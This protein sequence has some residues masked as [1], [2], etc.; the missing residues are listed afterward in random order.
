VSTRARTLA[1]AGLVVTGAFFVSR[2][3]GWL[4]TV[5]TAYLFGASPDLDAY[6]AAFRI[7]DAI[8]QL[9]AAG[10]LSS[11]LIPVLSGLIANGEDSR[12]WRVVS[13]VVNL[14]LLALAAL[15]VVLAIAAP[16]IVPAITPGFDPAQTEL[17]VRL[18]RIML[19]SPTLLA[20]GAVATSVLNTMGRFSAS[21]LAPIVY[22]V[23]IILG[24]IFLSPFIGVEGLAIGVVV[25]SLAHLGIQLP[26]I[27]GRLGVRYEPKLDLTDPAAREA[28][29]R[30]RYR[31]D[32]CLQRRV[33][34]SPDPHRH[35]RCSTRHRSAALDVARA[36]DR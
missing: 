1:T 4:R 15:S 7:P 10:A 23:G 27:F 12:A 8:F 18:S 25:G 33:H 31:C 22:N 6:F 20:L 14:M 5:V 3:L 30:R 11:A 13:T 21:A 28:R 19:I 36:R 17:T 2:V 35:H 9:V 32:R 26:Q 29:V 34:G 16:V 24:A